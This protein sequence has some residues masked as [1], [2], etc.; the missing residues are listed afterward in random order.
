[1]QLKENMY[2]R[3][4]IVEDEANVAQVMRVRLESFGYEVCHVASS[5]IE[6]IRAAESLFPD[7]VIMD[8]K[9]KGALDGIECAQQ[10][11]SRIEVPIIYLTSY[12]DD[13]LLRRAQATDPFGYIVKPYEA[14]QLKITI[15]MALYKHRVE[16]ER[17]QLLIDLRDALGKVK[18][19]SGLLPICSSCK[20]IRDDR[21]YWNQL[22]SYI[23]KHS[24]A[25]FTH[26]ICPECVHKL[27]P[28]II[29]HSVIDEPN[30]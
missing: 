14:T 1:M 25:E 27:Y 9:I 19:L 28:G 10:I 4:L 24:E 2:V 22:E 15:E 29:N 23:Q 17:K 13:Q 3:I 7:I 12:S 11:R 16:H 8:I 26:S 5:G 18:M 6:A 21:G 20:K 30:L